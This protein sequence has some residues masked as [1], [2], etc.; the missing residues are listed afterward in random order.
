MRKRTLFFRLIIPVGLSVFLLATLMTQVTLGQ[1]G[2][3]GGRSGGYSYNPVRDFQSYSFGAG[4]LPGPTPASGGGPLGSSIYG[5]GAPAGAQRQSSGGDNGQINASVPSSASLMAQGGNRTTRVYDPMKPVSFAS[6]AGGVTALSV[7]MSQ[8]P[9][10]QIFKA[11][12]D[13]AENADDAVTLTRPA[14][15]SL[16]PP[17]AGAFR[18]AMLKGE[19]ELKDNDYTTATTSFEAAK[20]AAPGAPEPLLSLFH[21]SL[22]TANGDYTQ[23]ADYLGQTL[24][25]FPHLPLARV[26]PTDF[27]AEGEFDT[28]LAGLREHVKENEEDGNALFVLGYLEWRAAEATDAMK[29]LGEAVTASND[30]ELTKSVNLLLEGIGSLRET[31]I[32]DAPDMQPATDFDWAGVRMALPDG[33]VQE[34]LTH[35]N[36]I[37]VAAG[38]TA[39]APKR[40]SLMIYPLPHDM[41]LTPLMDAVTKDIENRVGVLDLTNEGDATVP[42]FDRSALVRVLKLDYA[43]NTFVGARMCFVRQVIDPDGKT[44]H[45]AYVLGLG[46]LESEADQV[47]PTLAAMARSIELLDF[48]RPLDLPVPDTGLRVSDPQL[49][50]AITQPTGWVGSFDDD[51]FSMGQFDFLEGGVV[52]PRVDVITATFPAGMTA[53][54]VCK[55]ALE[56]KAKEGFIMTV[57]SHREV[58]LAGGDGYEVLF[59]KTREATDTQEAQS[60]IEMGRVVTMST[61][62][63]KERMIALVVRTTDSTPE[64]TTAIMEAMAPKLSLINSGGSNDSG[65]SDS[66]DGSE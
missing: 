23:S 21:V 37:F 52:S 12:S 35:I 54:E 39:E 66:N 1:G 45:V 6:S 48:T 11:T 62:G 55:N 32:A 53:K 5:G 31:I 10:H 2:R 13:L 51:G 34:R 33:F 61:D 58:Q 9:T 7:S 22:A 29:V 14:L 64:K 47:L 18:T 28:L 19:Q 60:W 24:R 49:G 42:F 26:Y 50:F 41:E 15:T 16:A 17:E 46:M 43:G 57:I 25:A 20:N 36:N 44:R 8:S 65:D 63:D 4:D 59:K 40:T 27:Y 56:T 38:G 3:W 30:K